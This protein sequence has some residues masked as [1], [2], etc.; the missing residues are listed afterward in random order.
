MPMNTVMP[1]GG[2]REGAGRPALPARER[3]RKR[4]VVRCNDAQWSYMEQKA[5][6]AGV[7]LVDWARQRLGIH[8][9][10]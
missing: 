10:G 1:R 4:L 2:K 8:R 3:L 6:K 5:A 9:I 7:D